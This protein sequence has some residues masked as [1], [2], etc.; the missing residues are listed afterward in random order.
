MLFQV[1]LQLYSIFVHPAL[2]LFRY[3]CILLII[4]PFLQKKTDGGDL[5]LLSGFDYYFWFSLVQ[6]IPSYFKDRLVQWIYFVS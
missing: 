1:S 4:P 2:S 6:V 5:H 3:I